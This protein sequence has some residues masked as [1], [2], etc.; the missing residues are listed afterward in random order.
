MAKREEMIDR[1]KKLQ[2][3]IVTLEDDESEKYSLKSSVEDNEVPSV[4][5]E[6]DEIS[7]SSLESHII[8][9][10]RHRGSSFGLASKYSN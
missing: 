7:E 1:R 8:P 9:S 4:L 10:G 3:H 5:I 6:S 2:S